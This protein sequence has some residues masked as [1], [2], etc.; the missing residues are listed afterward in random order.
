MSL[1]FEN[2]VL[3]G[4]P[5]LFAITLHEAAHG[6]VARY[7]GDPTA[8]KAKRITLNP[9]AH[10]D[11]IGTLLIPFGI[12]LAS[13]GAFLFGY[14]K[15]VPVNP[16]HFKNPRR[17]MAWVALAGPFA[18]LLM[19]VFWAVV[20]K[21][22]LAANTAFF[23]SLAKMAASGILVNLVLI[24]LNLLPIPP[25]DGGRVAVGILP[26]PLAA[27]L[28]KVEPYGFFIILFLLFTQLLGALMMPV[29]EALMRFLS[30]LFAIYP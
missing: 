16:F 13:G 18:N 7:L 30:F 10:V 25:L 28:N 4:I 12:L 3:I 23:L 17:D 20:L 24:A 27:A 29:V 14:A 8:E 22:C 2:L 11:L 5:V 9:I 26:L 6:Y 15:P 21:M 19:A 1:F